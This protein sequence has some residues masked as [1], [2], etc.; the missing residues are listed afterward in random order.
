MI[1]RVINF[2]NKL[3]KEQKD[4]EYIK[5]IRRVCG[6]RAKKFKLSDT[7]PIIYCEDCSSKGCARE[8]DKLEL[9]YD[10]ANIRYCPQCD[11]NIHRVDNYFMYEQAIQ[12]NQKFAISSYCFEQIRESID[13]VSCE[14][15]EDNLIISKFILAWRFH[16]EYYGK[17]GEKWGAIKYPYGVGESQFSL[18]MLYEKDFPLR[19][20][21]HN[22]SDSKSKIYNEIYSNL[23][24]KIDNKIFLEKFMK[25]M[26]ESAKYHFTQSDIE[27]LEKFNTKLKDLQE[28]LTN[29][30]IFLDN[31]LKTRVKNIDDTLV[32]YELSIH[33]DF[34]LQ[35]DNTIIT[36]LQEYIKNISAS[37]DGYS[38]RSET[39]NPK[40]K[41][42]FLTKEIIY[43]QYCW[44]FNCLLIDNQLS[45]QD[46][47]TIGKITPEIKI[48][49]KHIDKPVS[50]L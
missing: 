9:N 25:R 8:W 44:W 16:H 21:S 14:T 22:Y 1:P 10:S 41:E 37:T 39:D 33:L 31:H 29:E 40:I 42:W 11:K 50:Y 3:E 18:D 26:D 34:Y 12:E 45:W 47:L 24:A 13:E 30:A 36:S 35:D 38:W 5:E 17:Q 4:A 43:K 49:Y 28:T 7:T 23:I 2:Y 48:S 15:L 19:A 6:T 20:E 46:V 27:S 32:D